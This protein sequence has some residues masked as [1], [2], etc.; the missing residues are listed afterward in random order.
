MKILLLDQF[1]EPGGAQSMMLSVLEAA[2][3]A[4]W[5]ALVGMPGD[6]P[7]F[8]RIEQIGF[9]TTRLRCGPFSVGTK[10]ISD[11]IRFAVQ[12]PRLV[13]QIRTL[14]RRFGP[15]LLYI[16]G[17]RLLPAAAV[18]RLPIPALFHAHNY[19]PP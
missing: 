6:G 19:L 9:E 4:G 7:L 3:G 15:D 8:R 1:S 13:A 12:L 17:P 18:A 16:N 14:A 2:R 11:A 10:S 5:E